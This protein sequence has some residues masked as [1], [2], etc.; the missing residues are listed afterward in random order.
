LRRRRRR[1]KKKEKEEEEGE[2][3]EEEVPFI[4][5]RALCWGY[6]LKWTYIFERFEF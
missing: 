5:M 2:E 3:E 6:N 1:R 4:S